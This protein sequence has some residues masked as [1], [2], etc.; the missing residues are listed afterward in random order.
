MEQRR[1]ADFVGRDVVL[2]DQAGAAHDRDP[3]RINDELPATAT[4]KILK[5]ARGTTYRR[6]VQA[7][8]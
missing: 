6:A 2:D 1:V 7:S 8:G 4:N 5:R 3:V